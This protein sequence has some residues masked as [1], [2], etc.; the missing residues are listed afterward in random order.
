MKISRSFLAIP[1][2][3]S[4]TI[5]AAPS[6]ETQL[7]LGLTATAS[8]PVLISQ[9]FKPP[10]R[11]APS[12][13]AGGATRGSCSVRAKQLISLMPKEV[14][15]AKEKLGLT[16]SDH[17]TFFWHAP[18]A[19][20]Q[21][22]NFLLLGSR[23]TEVVYEATFKL[24]KTPGVIAFKLPANA[25]ALA[26]GKQYHWFLSLPCKA[27]EPDNEVSVS[28]W[29]ERTQPTVVL[30]KAL[31]K[32]QPR[33]QAILYAEAGIWHEA[34]ATLAQLRQAAPKDAQIEASW[35]TL[36]TSVGLKTV[37]SEPMVGNVTIVQ[38]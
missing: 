15:G 34:I 38:K 19:T 23:D 13:T 31:A 3:L 26:P 7:P 8:Q 25:P 17:P 35:Q 33:S 32:A 22:A 2:S 11:G 37:A 27:S 5:V 16:I 21:T 18:Q 4:A 20:G 9:T 1:L 6:H 10:N 36:L 14:A 29:V 28:G 24:P 12:S 30:T